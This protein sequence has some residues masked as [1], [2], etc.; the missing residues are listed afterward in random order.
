MV[1]LLAP[2]M[3]IL[4]LLATDGMAIVVSAAR[5]ISSPSPSPIE[6]RQM[7]GNVEDSRSGETEPVVVHLMKRGPRPLDR[8]IAG[9]GVIVGGLATTFLVAVFC[10]LR[11][12]RRK[13]AQQDD[14][15]NV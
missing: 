11:A 1:Q 7:E 6:A 12:T 13:Q 5:S 10:Y 3:I 8:S 9:G 14:S 15:S 2:F 4:I